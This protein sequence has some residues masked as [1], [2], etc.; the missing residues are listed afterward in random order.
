MDVATAKGGGSSQTTCYIF[1]KNLTKHYFN[2]NNLLISCVS[3]PGITF[4][5]IDNFPPAVGLMLLSIFNRSKSAPPTDWP[6]QAYCLV[7]REDL[8]ALAHCAAALQHSHDYLESECTPLS[9]VLRIPACMSP[10]NGWRIL[11]MQCRLY[12]YVLESNLQRLGTEF[13]IFA[14]FNVYADYVEG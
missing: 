8:A 10:G 14:L 7:M 1:N 4:Q 12:V 6:A 13:G 9:A 11:S 5:G 3:F 2:L